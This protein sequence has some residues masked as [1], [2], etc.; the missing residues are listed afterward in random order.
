MSTPQEIIE[1]WF[2]D[3]DLRAVPSEATQK[4]WF[5]GGAAF[6]DEV[7]ARFGALLE[8]PDAV[9]AWATSPLG[10]LAAIVALDQFPRNI[11]RGTARGFSYDARARELTRRC[12]ELGHDAAYGSHQRR[13]AYLP[14]MH[15]EDLALQREAVARYREMS[16]AAVGTPD[17]ALAENTLRY[18]EK[19]MAIIERFGRF[20]GRN[21]ALGR[22]DT[23]EE[24]AWIA[25]GGESFGQR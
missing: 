19:H 21:V 8:A 20:P 4:R 18:A 23:P 11:F 24:R 7:R 16:L 9:V 5:A 15:G 17:A 10:T 6:D 13:F 12:V 25:A 1:F 22:E 14:L 3:A 2:G